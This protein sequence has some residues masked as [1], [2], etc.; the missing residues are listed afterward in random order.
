M[1]YASTEKAAYRNQVWGP[2]YLVQGASSDIGVLLL[3]PGDEMTNHIHQRCDESF[4]VIEGTATL[5]VSCSERHTLTVGDV[6]RCAAGEMHYFSNDSPATFRC[7]FI[8]S[9]ASPGDTISL[10]WTP[11]ET[12]PTVPP[13]PTS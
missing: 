8:K 6:Y 5:W 3:R 9:P 12:A 10:P 13:C 1:Q 11:G 2:A 7:V 4:I